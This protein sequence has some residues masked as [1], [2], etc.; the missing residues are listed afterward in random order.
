MN[1]IMPSNGVY[2]MELIAFNVSILEKLGVLT[3]FK[4]NIYLVDKSFVLRFVQY[5]IF[6]S[7]IEQ[8]PRKLQY[9]ILVLFYWPIK[10]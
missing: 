9:L 8:L 10:P 5:F 6:F 4:Y 7:T 1:M 2:F 3:I